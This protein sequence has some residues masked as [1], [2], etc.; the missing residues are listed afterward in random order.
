MS[1]SVSVPV[2]ESDKE[3]IWSK[4]NKISVY[5]L[6]QSLTSECFNSSSSGTFDII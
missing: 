1:S 2:G 6:A 4:T 5:L 3:N